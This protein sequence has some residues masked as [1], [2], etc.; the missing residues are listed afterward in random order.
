MLATEAWASLVQSL[1]PFLDRRETVILAADASD[2]QI[3]QLR[4]SKTHA[5]VAAPAGRLGQATA[6]ALIE[7]GQ[8]RRVPDIIYVGID[9]VTRDSVVAVE[10][11]R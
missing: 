4:E 8:G 11:P 10:P 7:I 1:R 2:T 9:I 5:L 3:R 6:Q